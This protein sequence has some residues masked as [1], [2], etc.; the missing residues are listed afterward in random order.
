MARRRPRQYVEEDPLIEWLAWLMD[1]SIR[2]GPWKVG[3]DGFIGLIPGIGDMAGSAVS[4][5]IIARAMQSGISKGAVVRMVINV[6]LDSLV[7]AV[8]FLGDVFDFAFKS[9]SY[10]VQIYREAIRGER[11]PLRDWLFILLVSLI[12][13]AIVLLPIVGLV[14]LTRFLVSYIR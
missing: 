10:N 14:F 5:F 13:L 12:L 2:I 6:A 4:A 1:D 9:N 3:L 11:Q 8:P 7:G